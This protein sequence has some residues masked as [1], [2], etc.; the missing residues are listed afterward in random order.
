MIKYKLTIL[1]MLSLLSCAEPFEF[2][3]QQRSLVVVDGKVSTQAGESYVIVNELDAEGE[4]IPI[5]DLAVSILNNEGENYTFQYNSD[6]NKYFPADPNFHGIAGQSYK[7]EAQSSNGTVLSSDY[8]LISTPYAFSVISRDTIERRLSALNVI[9]ER[10]G[11]AALAVIP[12]PSREVYSKLSF[13]YSYL[14]PVTLEREEVNFDDYVLHSCTNQTNCTETVTIPV[15]FRL[16]LPWEF[17]DRSPPCPSEPNQ[18][19]LCVENPCCR[20]EQSWITDF[21]IVQETL[22]PKSY[23]YFKEIKRLTNNNGLVFD[24]YPFQL[25]GN[26]ECEDCENEVVGIFRAVAQSSATVEVII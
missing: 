15:G 26:I 24:T 20:L 16:N 2:G 18:S 3:V 9:M 6:C 11:T 13:K 1:T 12:P 5:T 10:D 19:I 21:E 14:S 25:K 22:T 4:L 23:Q 7:L 8:E 17:Y